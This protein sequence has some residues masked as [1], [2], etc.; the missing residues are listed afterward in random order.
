[1]STPRDHAAEGA[2]RLR[3]RPRRAPALFL[4]ALASVAAPLPAAEPSVAAPGAEAP[5]R[6]TELTAAYPAADTVH[7]SEIREIRLRYS[8]VVQVP[9]STITVTGP[10]GPLPGLGQ[11]DTVPGSA[12]REIR[13]ALAA[14]LPTGDY[15]VEWTTAGPD[16]HPLRGSYAFRVELPEPEP[17][18]PVAEAAGDPDAGAPALAPTD[19][20][21][22]AGLNPRA[23]VGVAVRG[24]FLLS[25]VGMLGTAVFRLGVL[26]PMARDPLLAPVASDAGARARA[27]AWAAAGAAVVA[28]PARLGKQSSD[29]FGEAAFAP[30]SLG[31]LLGTGWGGAWV[32]ELAMAALFVVGLLLVRGGEDR[33]RGW[34]TMLVAGVG[35]ALVPPLSGHAAGAAE[36]VRAFAVLND[37]THVVAAGVWMGGLG[38][39]LLAGIGAAARGRTPVPAPAGAGW[40]AEEGAGG[41][42]SGPLREEE[43]P[44]GML[45]PLARMV[46]GFSRV[47]I[48]AVA[49]LVATGAVSAW[50]Q[51]GSVGALFGSGYGRTLLFKLVLVAAA[52]SLGFY[53]WRVVRPTLASDPRGSLIRIPA[54]VE[55]TLGVAIVLVT[56]VL[57]STPLPGE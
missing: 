12:G 11:V 15:T 45:A 42:D 23:P 18:A 25:I 47:A 19:P 20:A 24:L 54:S 31:R 33:A 43:P 49:V 34:G 28:L 14:P 38:A 4:L 29:L 8:T 39:M 22:D 44:A 13:V 7:G 1:M 41:P 35:M 48:V 5:R 6:H 57:I 3:P 51:L 40:S 46:T 26:G 30:E 27:L 55:A 10:R 37:A 9:L 53:N 2:L 56:A 32:L 21:D 17:P 16:S 50:L 36:P 52:A